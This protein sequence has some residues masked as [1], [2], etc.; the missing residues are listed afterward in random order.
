MH[1]AFRAGAQHLE[2]SVD[3]GLVRGHGI[4]NRARDRGDGR[5]VEH[6]VGAAQE[7]SDLVE[8]ADVRDMNGHAVA[9]LLEVLPAAGR[10]VVDDRDLGGVPFEE[11]PHQHGANEAGPS[12]N[13]VFTHVSCAM[14]ASIMRLS[15]FP[16]GVRQV[17]TSP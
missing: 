3:V 4:G 17:A 8:T 11:L 5:Q 15:P 16:P 14:R 6:H 7:R 13:N 2:R 12:G 10:E 1:A 9:E